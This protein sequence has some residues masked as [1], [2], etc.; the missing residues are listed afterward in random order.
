MGVLNRIREWRQKRKIEKWN[1]IK[2]W[3]EFGVS[4]KPKPDCFG[5]YLGM[6]EDFDKKPEDWNKCALCSYSWD[7]SEE[8]IKRG[9]VKGYILRHGP[10][11]S[12]R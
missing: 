10:T 1:K 6:D 4:P 9:K 2:N 11:E 7:C 12:F 3:I 8:M 5:N